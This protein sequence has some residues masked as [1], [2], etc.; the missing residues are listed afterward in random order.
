MRANG[1][2]ALDIIAEIL[3]VRYGDTRRRVTASPHMVELNAEAFKRCRDD[4]IRSAIAFQAELE[5]LIV[6][7]G[8][9]RILTLNGRSLR[10]DWPMAGAP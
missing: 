4:M 8:K 9:S 6:D 5:N 2:S 3:D 7:L 10:K 1:G